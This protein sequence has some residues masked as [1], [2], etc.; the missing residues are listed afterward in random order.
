MRYPAHIPPDDLVKDLKAGEAV[1]LGLMSGSSLDG[2]DLCLARFGYGPQRP[3]TYRILSARTL[4]YPAELQERLRHS[5]QGT[6]SELSQ[7]DVELGQWWG[8]EIVAFLESYRQSGGEEAPILLASHGHTV[9]H[10]PERGYT[11]QIGHPAWLH[12]LTGLP[13][14]HDFRSA[15]VAL[16]GQ[17]APLVPM[18]DDLLFGHYQACLNLGGIANVS[19]ENNGVRKACDLTFCNTAL[20]RFAQR[21]GMAM[22]RDGILSENGRLLPDVLQVW[23]AAPWYRETG[24]RSLD[25][26]TFEQQFEP[27]TLTQSYDPGDLCYTWCEHSAR[28][29]AKA[30]DACS[31]PSDLRKNGQVLLSGGGAAHPVLLR[32]LS[33]K[34]KWSPVVAEAEL[35]DFKEALIF[36]LLG[37]LHA[38]G[39]PNVLGSG[40]GAPY[41]H[42]SGSRIG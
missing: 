2:V 25:T 14:I 26:A 39:R 37:L 30:L 15:D 21:V 1:V 9:D 24:A 23:D 22:D 41:H 3:W 13:V 10:R 11:Y 34:T 18:G 38:L 31:G 6:R 7:L 17:G 16:G 8:H 35:R 32:C 12:A 20:N 27:I 36:G 33:Q 28:V 19:W 42:R 4:P 29:L 5:P 40:T